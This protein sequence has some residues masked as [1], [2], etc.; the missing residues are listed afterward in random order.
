V[1][2][3]IETLKRRRDDWCAHENAS[4]KQKVYEKSAPKAW[5]KLDSKLTK[6]DSWSKLDSK[7]TELELKWE[8]QKKSLDANTEA[9]KRHRYNWCA[10]KNASKK[11]NIYEKL[12]PKE[13]SLTVTTPTRCISRPYSYSVKEFTK[14]PRMHKARIVSL[15]RVEP[16]ITTTTTTHTSRPCSN[17]SKETILETIGFRVIFRKVLDC[18]SE[19]TKK[20]MY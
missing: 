15:C 5:S 1:D 20:R 18:L 2:A 16:V 7:L 17:F 14:I 8:Q 6:E 13:G 9:L 12:A 3:N 11:L 4:K 19:M 10:L